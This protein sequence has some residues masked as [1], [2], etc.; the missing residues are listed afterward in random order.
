MI[1]RTPKLTKVQ[2]QDLV[3]YITEMSITCPKFRPKAWMG[4]DH[5][6]DNTLDRKAILK[7]APH[8]V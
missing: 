7:L 6:N 8:M 1:I 5:M 4:T 3:L 2:W